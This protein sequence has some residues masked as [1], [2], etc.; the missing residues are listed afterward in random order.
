MSLERS[1]QAQLLADSA[2]AAGYK[3]IFITE[4]EAEYSSKS[5]GGPEKG[6]L[7]FQPYYDEQVAKTGGQF[8]S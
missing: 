3:K 2:E 1:C 4:E 5:V 8:L 6:W 7:A